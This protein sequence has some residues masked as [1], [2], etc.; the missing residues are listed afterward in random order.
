M[1]PTVFLLV[2]IG[3][4]VSLISCSTVKLTGLDTTPTLGPRVI[5]AAGTFSDD[6]KLR[7]GC[8]INL[9]SKVVCIDLIVTKIYYYDVI[10]GMDWTEMKAK[11][12]YETWLV[13]ARG[14]EGASFTFPVQVNHPFRIRC[15]ASLLEDY[16]D[17]SLV[18]TP[19]VRDFMDVF[20]TIPTLP[21]QCEIDFTID[22]VPGATPISL[23]T[24]VCLHAR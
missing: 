10:I 11:I 8:P 3:S 13:T 21:P 7:R 24:I 4:T 12:N 17:P 9:G 20:K 1:I 16:D 6:T 5:T 22:L 14:A 19:I 2:E 15:Y 18:A 23:P